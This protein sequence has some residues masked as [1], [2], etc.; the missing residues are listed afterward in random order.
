MATATVKMSLHLSQET[1]DLVEGLCEDNHLTKSDLMR[2]AVALIAVAL[3]YKKQG[4]HLV[5]LDD[6]N[7]KMSEIV[8]L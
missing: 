2:R 4:G 8:G 1:N 6:K 7:N 5:V 3:K